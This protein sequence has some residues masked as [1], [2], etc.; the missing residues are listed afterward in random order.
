MSVEATKALAR[1]EVREARCW[2][3]QALCCLENIS[4]LDETKRK[5]W[6][7]GWAEAQE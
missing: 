4:Q 5:G 6:Q 7:R 3:K 1:A 2:Q